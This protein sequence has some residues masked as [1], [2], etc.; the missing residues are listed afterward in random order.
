M[1]TQLA[2]LENAILSRAHHLVDTQHQAAQQQRE[3]ILADA[4]KQVHFKEERETE[5][6]KIA[7]EQA[8]RRQVQASEIKLHAQ[9]DQLRWSL[10]QSVMSKLHARLQEVVKHTDSYLALLQQYF[11]QAAQVIEREAL[12]VEANERDYD[13]LSKHWVDFTEHTSKSCSLAKSTQVMTG[14]IIVT[15]DDNRIRVD[16]SFEG[17]VRQLEDDIYQLITALLFAEAGK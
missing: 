10:I 2:A 11:G 16:Y 1:N 14:G 9:L 5:T 15:S 3:K 4:N 12:I 17:L 7:A 13:L 8:Y 6:A